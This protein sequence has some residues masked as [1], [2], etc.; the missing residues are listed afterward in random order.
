MKKVSFLLFIL[1]IPQITFAQAT[2][3][4]FISSFGN[5][6]D[7]ATPVALGVALL[8]FVWGLATFIRDSGNPDAKEEGRNKMIWGV[9][10]LFVIVAIWGIIE[11]IGTLLGVSQN[12]RDKIPQLGPDQQFP[13]NSRRITE[14][15]DPSTFPSAPTR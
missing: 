11:F 1:L 12:E 14:P 13:L 9:V 15:I 4:N 2:V 3:Q 8:Y 7:I 6:I 5:L 10:S